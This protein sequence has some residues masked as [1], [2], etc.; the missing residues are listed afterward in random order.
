MSEVTYAIQH[1]QMN[2]AAIVDTS[3]ART[4]RGITAQVMMHVLRTFDELL[5][6]DEFVVREVD[7]DTIEIDLFA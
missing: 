4:T 2:M 6:I 5:D 1:P 3:R 7:A